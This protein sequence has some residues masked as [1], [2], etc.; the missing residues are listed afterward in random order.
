MRASEPS[1]LSG[2]RKPKGRA[3][4]TVR[5][6]WVPL[7]L[8]V[9][10]AAAVTAWQ[11]HA[12]QGE[13]AKHVAEHRSRG[14]VVVRAVEGLATRELRGRRYDPV[15]LEAALEEALEAFGLR[16]VSV[17]E[18]GGEVLAS[19]G[20]RPPQGDP[21]HRFEHAFEPLRPRQGGPGPRWMERAGM[22]T[23]DATRLTLTLFTSPDALE[24]NFR[25]VR[26]DFAVT[27]GSLLLAVLFLGGVSWFRSRSSALRVALEAQRREVEGLERLRRVG[28]GLVHE[29]KNPLAVVRGFAERILHRPL[30]RSSLEQAAR[31]IVDETDRTLARLDEFL[32]FSRPAKLRRERVPLRPLFD[33]LAMLVGPELDSKEASIDVNCSEKEL[34][35]DRDQL[36]RLL[37]NLLLNAIQAMEPGGRLWLICEERDA[38]LQL[39]VE[40]D[41]PGVPRAVRDTLFEPY[42]SMRSGGS[43]LGLS[44]ARRIAEDHGF[45]LSYEPRNPRGAR[46]V[47]E[48]P[49]S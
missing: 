41:G 18:E 15:A 23:L 38:V 31:A 8:S 37:L 10:A 2:E 48:A 20:T 42:V 36:R 14:G 45:T 5:T 17:G 9:V 29:T 25:Q 16:S 35:A 24:A 27:L 47:L 13:R 34:N 21:L 32:L 19:V 49:R 44:I 28:T 33:E 1:T 12:F 6:A 43:G 11:W 7:L 46:F 30:D 22:P 3:R 40:D 4:Q 26:A 39:A